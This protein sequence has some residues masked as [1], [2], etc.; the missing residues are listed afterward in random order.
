[1]LHCAEHLLKDKIMFG[2]DYPMIRPDDWLASFFADTEFST[3]TRRK[4]LRESAEAF[5]GL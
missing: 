2:T 3:E 4:I 1:M 5:L